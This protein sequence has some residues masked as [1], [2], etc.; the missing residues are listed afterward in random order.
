M[1]GRLP[2]R[3]EATG[4]QNP[5][6]SP[7]RLPPPARLRRGS[8]QQLKGLPELE[9]PAD[10]G[11]S[12]MAARGGRDAVDTAP[13]RPQRSTG[14]P[15]AIVPRALGAYRRPVNS[16]KRAGHRMITPPEGDTLAYGPNRP[17]LPADF[18]RK[19]CCSA[20]SRI[21]HA[22]PEW[23]PQWR[24]GCGRTCSSDFKPFASRHAKRD[25]FGTYQLL[26]SAEISGINFL[27]DRRSRATD[28][29]S[30]QLSRHDLGPSA[31]TSRR[32][33]SI[34]NATSGYS[35]LPPCA[36]QW[37]VRLGGRLGQSPGL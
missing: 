24:S 16:D 26:R 35:E 12:R 13:L 18:L 37:P 27:V 7:T 23:F 36:G 34:R 32:P 20:G 25:R 10:S 6:Y 31:Q 11:L 14:A 29:A 19:G 8:A 22:P 21:P 30:V 2:G 5:A 9:R 1:D 33:V 17:P 28:Q 4:R 3:R 15:V